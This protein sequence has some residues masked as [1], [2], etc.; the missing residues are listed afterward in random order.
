M[1]LECLFGSLISTKV[2]FINKYHKY[3]VAKTTQTNKQSA[4]FLQWWYHSYVNLFGYCKILLLIYN[5]ILFFSFLNSICYFIYITH[6]HST[7]YAIVISTFT[8]SQTHRPANI[9]SRLISILLPLNTRHQLLTESHL[10]D[11]LQSPSVPPPLTTW[12]ML[13]L[14]Y[15][16]T[17]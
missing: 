7:R 16:A 6:V 10:N 14:C 11:L 13:L 15:S 9:L 5:Y 3:R 12:K 8:C 4:T 1:L 2:E 17:Y